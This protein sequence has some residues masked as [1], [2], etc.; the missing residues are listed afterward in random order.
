MARYTGPKAKIARKFGEP[1]YGTIKSKKNYPP[2]QHGNSHRRKTSEYGIQLREKQKAKYTYGVLERQFRNLFE[3]ASRMKGVKGEVL[4]QLLEQRLDNVVYR[5]G[6][7]KTRDAARQL[8]SHRHIVVDGKVV[9]IPSFSVQP[10]QVVGVRERS[11]SLEVISDSVSAASHTKYAW[12]EW[13]KG[14]MS[15]KFLHVPQRADIPENIKEQLIV[16]LY[17]K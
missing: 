5:L 12:L 16:E 14:S 10:G 13:D 9:N 7:A 4:I 6:I 17:S 15:G 2:G 1:I 11:K 8:V 3:K